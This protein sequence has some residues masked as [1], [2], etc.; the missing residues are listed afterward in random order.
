MIPCVIY[1]MLLLLVYYSIMLRPEL[2]MLSFQRIVTYDAAGNLTIEC[3]KVD[4]DDE[5]PLPERVFIPS[6]NIKSLD[7]AGK[8]L[9]FELVN[10]NPSGL[11]YVFVPQEQ[12]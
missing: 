3:V 1:P 8:Y 7:Y 10:G 5:R 12:V 2:R 4:E 11:K 6:A 9:K